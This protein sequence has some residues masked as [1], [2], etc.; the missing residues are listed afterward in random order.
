MKLTLTSAGQRIGDDR[1][2]TYHAYL[3][4]ILAKMQ[5]FYLG[6]R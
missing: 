4:I 3:N 6:L 5:G 2:K 1:K